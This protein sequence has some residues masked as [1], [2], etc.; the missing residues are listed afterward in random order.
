M[1]LEDTLYPWLGLYER[2]TPSLKLAVGATYRRLPQRVRLGARYGAFHDLAAEVESWSTRQ[3]ADYQLDQL[4]TVLIHAAKHS[5]FYARHFAEAGFKPEQMTDLADLSGC[6]YVTKRN[7][8][9]E[10]Y[11]MACDEPS[12]SA[13]LRMTTGGSTGTPVAFFLHKGVSRPKEQAFLEAQWRRAGYF[14][15]ARLAVIRGRVTSANTR[16]SIAYYDPTRDWLML[17]SFHLTIERLPEYLQEVERFKPDVLHAYPST[18]LQ[19]AALL[20]QAGERWPAPLRCV[21]AGSE[22]LTTPQRQMLEETFAC[23]VYHWYGHRERVVLA[24]EGRTSNLLYFWPVYGY[25]EFGP[26][27]DTGLCEIIGTSFHNLVMPLVR[28][29][30]GDYRGPT[31]RSRTGQ[32]IRLACGARGRGPAARVPAGLGRAE[33]PAHAVQPKRPQLLRA[34]RRT[35]LPGLRRQSRAS[36]HAWA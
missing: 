26:P 15:G 12:R 4:R 34:L 20:D 36:L 18:A 27:D 2:L 22:R 30:T 14:E 31:T 21:L 3:I 13:R 17:S 19:L 16:G 5:P 33:D 7:I 9:D 24:G 28:Y 1:S 25:V 35:V 23:P 6:P 32:G 10:L 11:A 29:R 8:A